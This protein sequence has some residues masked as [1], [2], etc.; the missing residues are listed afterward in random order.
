MPPLSLFWARFIQSSTFHA[1]SLE[2]M[3]IFSHR[4]LGV[5]N[6]LCPSDFPTKTFYAFLF[7]QRCNIYPTNLVLLYILTQILYCGRS[8]RRQGVGLR[9]LDCWDRRFETRWGRGC[10]FRSIV[11]CCVG[12]GYC[13]QRKQLCCTIENT[14]FDRCKVCWFQIFTLSANDA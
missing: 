1:I 9:P 12:M 13:G 11:V 7:P 8:T 2:S 10:S 4:C 14:L 5:R 6:G 3:S